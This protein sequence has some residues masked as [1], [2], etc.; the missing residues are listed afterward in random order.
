LLDVKPLKR[1]R[2]QF[3]FP[4]E[5]IG[6]VGSERNSVREGRYFLPISVCEPP[7][8][9]VSAG[10]N[11]A[12]YSDEFLIIPPRQIGIASTPDLGSNAAKNGLLKAMALYL[13]SDFVTYHQFL[14]TPQMGIQRKVATLQALR[15]L[16]VP[17]EDIE[18]DWTPWQE[19]HEQR[20]LIERSALLRGDSNW[21]ARGD[22]ARLLEIAAIAN[23]SDADS[24]DHP[25][26]RVTGLR[27]TLKVNTSNEA[28]LT[29]THPR[30]RQSHAPAR[31]LKTGFVPFIFA[32]PYRRKVRRTLGPGRGHIFRL[33]VLPHCGTLSPIARRAGVKVFGPGNNPTNARMRPDV[34]VRNAKPLTIT[35]TRAA[36]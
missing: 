7:P 5:A 35:G 6:K 21:Y 8:I 23:A 22:G 12:V 1:K 16:P 30:G 19:L 25:N 27:K 33:H 2:F 3:E 11:F 13:N 36:A 18:Q 29:K 31:V 4:S 26:S 9:V 32:P 24:R 28:K 10:R 20:G 17:F 14:T 34:A 15:A